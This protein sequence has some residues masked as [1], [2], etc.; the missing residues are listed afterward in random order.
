MHELPA[1]TREQQIPR[2]A[3]DDNFL[4]RTANPCNNSITEHWL[5]LATALVFVV[6][7][8]AVDRHA[9]EVLHQVQQ[10][11]VALV[12]LGGNFEE[13]HDALVRPA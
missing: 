12:P 4:V 10:M 8:G 13:K 7:I 3:R 2:S 9:T 6:Q 1:N 5:Q 11:L